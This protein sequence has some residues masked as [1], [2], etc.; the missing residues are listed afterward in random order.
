MTLYQGAVA[1][2]DSHAGETAIVTGLIFASKVW[3]RIYGRKKDS[4]MRA[5]RVEVQ[6]RLDAHNASDAAAFAKIDLALERLDLTLNNGLREDVKEIKERLNRMDERA[7][8][9]APRGRRRS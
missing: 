5:N 4:E 7:L 9:Q 1:M 8:D 6:R 3:D 2:L